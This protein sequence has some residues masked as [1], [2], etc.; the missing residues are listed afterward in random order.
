MLIVHFATGI[1]ETWIFK[2]WSRKSGKRYEYVFDPSQ[3]LVGDQITVYGEF[4]SKPFD[5]E[6]EAFY[7]SHDEFIAAPFFRRQAFIHQLIDKLCASQWRPIHCPDHILNEDFNALVEFDQQKMFR[8]SLV[9]DATSATINKAGV[10][11][12]DTYLNHGL[13]SRNNRLL[14]DCWNDPVQLYKAI[15]Y[16]IKYGYDISRYIL[17]ARLRDWRGRGYAGP[18]FLDYR[19]VMHKATLS[20]AAH[21]SVVDLNPGYGARALAARALN[22]PYMYGDA[23]EAFN[24]MALDLVRLFGGIEVDAGNEV[25]VALVSQFE[26]MR[27]KSAFRIA[28]QMKG[29]ARYV[30]VCVDDAAVTGLRPL[31]HKYFK[32]LVRRPSPVRLAVRRFH[33]CFVDTAKI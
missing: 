15:R 31:T 24:D 29:R 7:I 20:W 28:R 5:S 22:I 17:L 26:P 9:I 27:G 33:L 8:G 30:L 1:K 2:K 4:E 21:M 11:I 14:S 25:D 3:E 6:D 18:D 16:L 13:Y 23:S 32:L 10:R 12:L 19:P